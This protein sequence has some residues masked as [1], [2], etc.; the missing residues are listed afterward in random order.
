MEALEMQ[1]IGTYRAE[2]EGAV[3]EVRVYVLGTTGR[4]LW[5]AASTWRLSATTR[6]KGAHFPARRQ[7]VPLP[8]GNRRNC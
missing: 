2:I 1:H 8:V 4:W 7:I 6:A 5:S 3:V